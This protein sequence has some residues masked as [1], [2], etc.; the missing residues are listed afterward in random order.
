[1]RRIGVTLVSILALAL[2]VAWWLTQ[3]RGPSSPDY[4]GQASLDAASWTSYSDAR[5][6]WSL[7]YPAVWHLQVVD[8]EATEVSCQGDAVVVSNFDGDLHHPDLGGA[9]CTG[10]WDMRNLRSN[11]VIVQIEVP[12]DVRPGPENSQRTTPLSL[13]DALQGRRLGRFGVPKG[14]WIP[15]YIDEGHQFFVRAWHGSDASQ[16]DLEIADE[17]VTSIRFDT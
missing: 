11:F 1:M 4:V 12:A 7:Q 6:G 13:D 2:V 10:A 16:K 5:L 14:I 17:I 9:S 8:P 15:V 3:V